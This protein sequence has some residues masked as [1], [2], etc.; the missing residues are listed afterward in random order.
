V[1]DFAQDTEVSGADGRYRARLSSDWEI[2]GPCGGY[3]AT[4]ALRA[5]VAHS[6]FDL[7]VSL[8][9]HF[10]GVAAFGD[11]EMETETL[12]AGRRS[13]SV[14][15]SMHQDGKP[16]CE[17]L[18]WLAIEGDGLHHD[19]TE[20]PAVAPPPAVPTIQEQVPDWI[21]WYPFWNNFEYRPIDW[22]GE[23]EWASTRPAAPRYDGWFRYLPTARFD[24]PCV[25]AGRIVVL[26]DIVGWPAATRA[27]PA[28]EEG[29]FIAPNVDLAVVFHQ[30][31]NAGEYLLLHGEAS[32]A[33]G[34]FIG[35]SGQVWSEDGRL[36]ASSVQQMMCRPAPEMRT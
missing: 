27:I 6:G 11:V 20:A 28:E 29:R 12:R 14:R 19:W 10:L 24:D 26:A 3:V 7:P 1:G 22:I 31:M 23:D 9:C 34:G 13:E 2:W 5:A 16:V 15:V 36:L 4:V 21:A 25:D 32:L 35:G 8:H 33:R 17:V 30:P 18:T